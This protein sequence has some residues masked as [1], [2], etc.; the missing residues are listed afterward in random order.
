MLNPMRTTLHIPHHWTEQ[1]F[2]KVLGLQRRV[3]Y[4]VQACNV[5][6]AQHRL[7]P[8]GSYPRIAD[9]KG[10]YDLYGPVNRL[11]CASYDRAMVCFLACLKVCPLAHHAAVPFSTTVCGS[12]GLTKCLCLHGLSGGSACAVGSRNSQ[13]MHTGRTWRQAS[14]R[15]L[16]CRMRSRGIR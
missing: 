7:L 12:V 14:G 9:R 16:T 3:T 13:T 8:M 1:V 11:M 2:D 6:F 5:S 15:R 4:G 10:T